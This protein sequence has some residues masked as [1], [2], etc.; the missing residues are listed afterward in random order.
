MYTGVVATKGA[1]SHL[2]IWQAHISREARLQRCAGAA[3]L[4][5]HTMCGYLSN[6]ILDWV[7]STRLA[8]PTSTALAE[9]HPVLILSCI[10]LNWLPLETFQNYT[11][12][13]QVENCN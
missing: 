5:G 6:L 3:R 11:T 13:R 9:V 2:P 1:Q 10:P 7:V 4:T 12:R 8:V